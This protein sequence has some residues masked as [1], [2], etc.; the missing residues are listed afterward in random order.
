LGSD[1]LQL[2]PEQLKEVVEQKILFDLEAK[3]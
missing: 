1:L 2:N 3:Q